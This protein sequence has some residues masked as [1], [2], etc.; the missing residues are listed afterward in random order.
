MT[1]FLFADDSG[2]QFQ[3]SENN[4]YRTF[5]GIIVSDSVYRNLILEI[6]RIEKY[7]F[8]S[9]Y[10]NP[11][12]IN[13]SKGRIH[14]I[15]SEN[16]LQE[17]YLRKLSK[18][19]TNWDIETIANHSRP[20]LERSRQR[21]NMK[22][23]KG[24][25]ALIKAKLE[26]VKEVLEAC[27]AHNCKIIGSI[28]NIKSHDINKQIPENILP[29]EIQR[30]YF[31]FFKFLNDPLIDGFGIPVF[32]HSNL[33]NDKVFQL[34][35]VNFLTKSNKDTPLVKRIIPE[36]LFCISHTSTFLMVADF[37]ASILRQGYRNEAING[38]FNENISAYVELLRPMFFSQDNSRKFDD[39][40]NNGSISFIK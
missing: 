30:I 6:R 22:D 29:I 33:R 27:N 10:A 21:L 7:F 4:H 40:F 17:S 20:F 37:V 5:A 34:L 11:D 15:K 39:N 14:E 16:F 24:L 8:G 32:D 28:V 31:M 36:P 1:Y 26:F 12:W 35:T 13:N 25:I 23:T 18:V 19:Y 2:H 3:Y 9:F 38:P